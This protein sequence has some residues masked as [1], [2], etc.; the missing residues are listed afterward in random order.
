MSCII[1]QGSIKDVYYFYESRS[2]S[3]NLILDSCQNNHPC[4]DPTDKDFYLTL[5]EEI[6]AGINFRECFLGYFA[7]IN[8]GELGFTADFVGI[9]FRA[10]SLTK[11]FAGINFH[12]SALYKDFAGVY[13]T[14]A[15]RNIFKE[16]F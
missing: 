7:G 15:L 16:W 3:L 11:D 1:L 9:N 2:Y 4:N 8:F 12:E 10:F 6:F 13:L 5:R 14:F